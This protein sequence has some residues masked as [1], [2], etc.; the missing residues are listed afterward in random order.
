MTVPG[1]LQVI[2]KYFPSLTLEQENLFSEFSVQLK[3]WNKKINL[4]SRK[5][6]EHLAERHILHS[7]S[8]AKIIS[9]KK[10]TAVLDAGTGGGFPGVPLAIMF[11]ESK[12]ILVDSVRKKINAVQQICAAIGLKNVQTINS[13]VEDTDV[14]CDFVVTRAVAPLQEVY[15]WTRTKIQRKNFNDLPNG[16][17]CLKGGDLVDEINSLKFKA[18]VYELKDFFEED[19]F[20]TKKVVYVPL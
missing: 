4:I 6:T 13:R 15:G 7:L 8:I 1:E 16:L 18:R 20:E 17:L 3:S 19:F 10:N 9:F 11:P 14:K 5:D 12:F 2:L